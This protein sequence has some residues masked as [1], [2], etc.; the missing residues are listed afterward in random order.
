MAPQSLSQE[1]LQCVHP[2]PPQTQVEPV[3]PTPAYPHFNESEVRRLL[4]YVQGHSPLHVKFTKAFYLLFLYFLFCSTLSKSFTIF[5]KGVK[6][7]RVIA[8]FSAISVH[9]SHIPERL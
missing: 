2:L 9:A 5:R 7:V 1:M 6:F 3:P 4:S 8:N